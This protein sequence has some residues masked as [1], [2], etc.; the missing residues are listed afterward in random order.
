[1]KCVCLCITISTSL[2]SPKWAFISLYPILLILRSISN[3]RFLLKSIFENIPSVYI[4]FSFCVFINEYLENKKKL[5]VLANKYL[6]DR[7]LKFWF[8]VKSSLDL[9]KK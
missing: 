3:N 6:S 9:K 2:P 7:I 8:N 4:L 5:P 1:M